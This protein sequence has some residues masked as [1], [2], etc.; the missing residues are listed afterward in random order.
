MAMVGYPLQHRSDEH[1]M[2]EVRSDCKTTT[3]GLHL[4]DT[5]GARDFIAVL[6]VR[7][8]LWWE[9]T[10]DTSEPAVLNSWPARVVRSVESDRAER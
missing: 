4:D 3:A 9:G 5:R 6:R 8:L 1:D 7:R 2:S 10:R